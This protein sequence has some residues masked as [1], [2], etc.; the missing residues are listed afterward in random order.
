MTRE[1]PGDLLSWGDHRGDLRLAG[2]GSSILKIGVTVTQAGLQ[3]SLPVSGAGE[4][5]LGTEETESWS[6]TTAHKHMRSGSGSLWPHGV[7]CVFLLFFFLILKI[8]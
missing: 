3:H 1:S 4:Q 7:K 5:N 6:M 2:R 8:S